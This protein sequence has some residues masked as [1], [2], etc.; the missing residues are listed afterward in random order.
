MTTKEK[1]VFAVFKIGAEYIVKYDVEAVHGLLKL[2]KTLLDEACK[3]MRIHNEK[4]SGK[5]GKQ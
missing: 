2:R 4:R 1:A 3:L 5:T